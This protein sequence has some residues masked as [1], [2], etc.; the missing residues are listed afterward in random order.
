[1]KFF[2]PRGRMRRPL[3]AVALALGLLAATPTPAPAIVG[4]EEASMHEF[5]WLI[6]IMLDQRPGVFCGASLISDRLVLTAAHC[7]QPF[8]GHAVAAIAGE[9]NLGSFTETSATRIVR[10][11]K[12]TVHPNYSTEEAVN[13]IALLEVESSLAPSGLCAPRNPDRPRA[14]A[15]RVGAICLPDAF[16]TLDPAGPGATVNVAGW[17]RKWDE[18]RTP[19][20]PHHVDLEVVPDQTCARRYPGYAT[21]TQFCT[22]TMGKDSCQGD[23]G[24]PLIQGSRMPGSTRLAY[25][26]VGLV[27]HGRECASTIDPTVSTDV[28]A[29]LP[30]IKQAAPPDT[31]WPVPR[32]S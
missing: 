27:S 18:G 24:G 14:D 10:V 1:M 2:R 28:A 19:E 15:V 7:V 4:G 25:A 30:W 16:P 12:T 22:W 9:H 3:T 29:Y 8:Q 20:V 31:V 11:T 5:P 26:L 6:G 21:A 13:D 32:A 23:S 17:G